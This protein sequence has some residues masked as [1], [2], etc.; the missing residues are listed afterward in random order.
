MNRQERVVEEVKLILKPHYNRKN[1][2]KEEYKDIMR[3][4]VPKVISIIEI[5]Q[6]FLAMCNFFVYFVLVATTQK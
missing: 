4:A 3:K 5:D 6:F 2:T 1:I